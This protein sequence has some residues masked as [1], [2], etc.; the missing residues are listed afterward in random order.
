ML[1]EFYAP[2]CG[3]C[4]RLEPIYKGLAEKLERRDNLVVAK[5]D[6]SANDVNHPG[7]GRRAVSACLCFGPPFLRTLQLAEPERH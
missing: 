7:V 2:W 5:M 6:I 3:H 1:L 4:N